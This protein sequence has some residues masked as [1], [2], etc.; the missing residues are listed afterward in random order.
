MK[1]E[2]PAGGWRPEARHLRDR[3]VTQWWRSL[4]KSLVRKKKN[5]RTLT[6]VSSSDYDEESEETSKNFQNLRSIDVKHER[7]QSK[8]GELPFGSL[9]KRQKREEDPIQ[10]VTDM[11]KK[12]VLKGKV[13]FLDSKSTS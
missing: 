12:R 7:P 1:S 9:A 4:K 5:D 3:Q 13:W 10:D 11:G 2:I 6:E 8:I